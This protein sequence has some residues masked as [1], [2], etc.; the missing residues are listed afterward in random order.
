M[1][2]INKNLTPEQETSI[3][4][5]DVTKTNGAV[6]LN[7]LETQ[8]S[9]LP[10]APVT[11]DN[12]NQ[13]L[14]FA[15]SLNQ[16]NELQRQ[17]T[18]EAQA[19]AQKQA[20]AQADQEAVVRTIAGETLGQGA[21]ETQALADSGISESQQAID[22]L[23]QAI[24]NSSKALKMAMVQD[25]R[26]VQSLAGQGRGIPASVV[27]GRQALL[28]SQRR[29]DRKVE[30][31]ELENDIATSEL[32]QG[33]VDSAKKAIQRSVELQ[34]AD[35]KAELEIEKDF[36]SRVDTKEANARKEA[37]RREEKQ[38]EKAQEEA[39]EVFNLA[40]KVQ[41]AG[42][43]AQEVAAVMKAKDRNEALANAP[44][45]GRIARMDMAIKSAELQK[46]Q[47]D[48]AASNAEGVV[49]NE[50]KAEVAQNKVELLKR[51][52]G[53]KLGL[54]ESVGTTGIGR[55][56]LS[57]LLGFGKTSDFEAAAKSFLAT[58]TLDT[59][60]DIKARGAT[61]GNLSDGERAA[62]G[63]AA[64]ALA[65]FAE[66]D[67]QGNPTGKFKGSEGVVSGHI[68]TIQKAYEKEFIA[69]GGEPSA[70]MLYVQETVPT[71]QV[72]ADGTISTGIEADSESVWGV[73]LSNNNI[74]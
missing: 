19:E 51:M 17:R 48:I 33:K 7:V 49:P 34:F 47:S 63:M 36:L 10:E 16:A 65:G 35:K 38:M 11:N 14:S 9:D 3:K 44:T 50:Q 43:S 24:L 66:Y 64:N 15:E 70:D 71:L 56:G 72:N 69:N 53:N 26:D 28:Q 2:T 18:A 37:I 22:A 59:L 60:I 13:T 55:V 58:D 41:E 12:T 30:A 31:I 73:A 45:L 42:G 54:V 5:Q 27:R 25:E 57:K 4:E 68:E 52:S 8:A 6:D 32:L 40:Q 74:Q 29:A 21:A 46:I 23:D 67:N 20:I 62:V 39:D 61:F 1:D